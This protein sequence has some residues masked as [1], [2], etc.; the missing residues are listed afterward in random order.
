MTSPA[1]L[2]IQR[3]LLLLACGGAA[4]LMLLAVLGTHAYRSAEQDALDRSR[5][6]AEAGRS[7][8]EQVANLVNLSVRLLRNELLAALTA[9][10]APATELGGMTAQPDPGPSRGVT[11]SFAGSI[12]APGARERL[13]AAQS[14]FPLQRALR[15]ASPQLRWSYV[16][17]ADR[18][19]V[20]LFPWVNPT[21]VLAEGE[22]AQDT[23][24][25]WW[26]YE[27]VQGSRTDLNP[28]RN[29]YWT[30]VYA[31]A[32]GTGLMVSH[33]MPLDVGGAYRATVGA[34]LLVSYLSDVIA[35][36]GQGGRFVVLDQKGNALAD[37]QRRV[38]AELRDARELLAGTPPDP[39]AG[40]LRV[41]GAYL[42][43]L[44]VSGTPWRL[45]HSV[46][47]NAV[48][49]AA[50]A[51]VVPYLILAA[52][53]LTG[54]GLLFAVM[55]Q[56]FLRPAARLANYAQ[57]LAHEPEVPAP[58]DVPALWRPWFTDLEAAVR[59]RRA[60]S[61]QTQLA[62]TLKAAVVDAALDAV[63]IADGEGRVIA[64][65]PGAE[66][67]FGVAAAD[68]IG[69]RIGDL[70]VPEELRGA[71]EAGMERFRRSRKATVLGRRLE[72]EAIRAG[73]TRFPVELAIHHVSVAGQDIFA[74][75]AR[76][77]TQQRE[78][79]RE[80]E[81]QQTRIYQ[82]EKLSA[83]GSLLA[84]VAHELNN[85]LA[86]L[87][88]QST[89]L[90]DK[91]D[92]PDLR[93]RAERIHAAAERAGRIVKSF[94]AMARQKPPERKPA[95]LN[96]V[97]EAALEM[98]AYGARGTGIE[99]EKALDPALPSAEIDRDM[100]GQVVANLLINAQQALAE[101]A[102]PRRIRVSTR[103]VAGDNPAERWIELEV[104]D[105]G[106]G[107]PADAAARIFDPYFTTKPAGVGTGIGLSI[108]RSVVE[109]HGGRIELLDAPDGGARFRI[110]MRATDGVAEAPEGAA[111]SGDG[112][113]FLV[114][115]DEADL[116]ASLAEMLQGL[117]HRATVAPGGAA[118]LD[119]ALAGGFDVVI[120]DLRM[121]GLDG[122]ALRRALIG[123]DPS[124][125]DRV[126]ITTG[127]TV[128]GPAAIARGDKAE[129]VLVL[130]KPF[131]PAEIRQAIAPLVEV[132][133]GPA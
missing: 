85:P 3:F 69:R 17:D 94:L 111:S 47:A 124:W 65:N 119:M 93:R 13:A 89:L 19:F 132:A 81:A 64:F 37:A 54:L 87:V 39:G 51:E 20:T 110:R 8:L 101:R 113:A 42:V 130:E 4:S 61:L 129:Q 88:A 126:V 127:D 23:L 34:D 66:R 9:G 103:A 117:G 91:A 123:H 97:V 6:E 1:R 67:I 82:I 116:A 22:A 60:L 12:Q 44:P 107:V 18:A 43:T 72:L 83:M 102:G 68:A 96:A 14:L 90:R 25:G 57:R 30:P 11:L 104:A 73:G 16:F 24:A 78:A 120:A 121:P 31:D 32:G 33:A 27:T 80:F 106:A 46:E 92:T 26:D 55:V 128:H 15:E 56:Q 70:I 118:A 62:E 63:I 109:A 36:S 52:V 122:M 133:P 105:N 29:A 41:G 125:A 131:G 10:P 35:E 95:S 108:C 75:Y 79:A 100:V 98:T 114:V 74:A 7:A 48:R 58:P 112:L 38:G 84:G 99:V 5:A 45:V 71:H 40:W 86:I 50:L 49:R 28:A 59:E 21:A 76:D 53:V 77:L 115:D 2:L